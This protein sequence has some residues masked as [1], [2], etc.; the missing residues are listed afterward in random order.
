MPDAADYP[1]QGEAQ[2]HHQADE[3]DWDDLV[4]LHVR[5]PPALYEDVPL[6]QHHRS[7]TGDER[8][9]E[10]GVPPGRGPAHVDEC[11]HRHCQC[12]DRRQ[13]EDVHQ[14]ERRPDR[15]SQLEQQPHR[16]VGGEEDGRDQE[17]PPWNGMDG[18]VI[19]DSG[20]NC[21]GRDQIDEHRQRRARLPVRN[22]H[23]NGRD[24]DPGRRV[25]VREPAA[26]DRIPEPGPQL[27]ARVLMQGAAFFRQCLVQH[28]K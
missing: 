19:P 14:Q 25:A 16:Q 13:L 3:H 18:A 11:R 8:A 1:V 6:P 12:D 20:R 21:A 4:R 26:R 28:P 7:A 27:W 22:N 24:G 23:L 2:R 17:C 9:V 10:E 15:H 5:D